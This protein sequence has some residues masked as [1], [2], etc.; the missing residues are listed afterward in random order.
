MESLKRLSQTS[1]DLPEHN[2]AEYF[3]KRRTGLSDLHSDGES[4]W[5]KVFRWHSLPSPQS[6]LCTFCLTIDFERLFTP[7]PEQPLEVVQ[8]HLA[9]FITWDLAAV[10]RNYNCPF[11][12]LLL[13]TL[14]LTRLSIPGNTLYIMGHIE[15]FKTHILENQPESILEGRRLWLTGSARCYDDYVRT[16]EAH[17]KK[18]CLD[19]RMAY[20]NAIVLGSS[21]TLSHKPIS[22]ACI[23]RFFSKCEETHGNSCASMSLPSDTLIQLRV[24]DIFQNCLVKAPR[25][26]KYFALSYVWGGVDQLRLT[27]QSFKVLSTPSSSPKIF[28][29]ASK[30][31]KDAIEFCRL[32][33]QPYLW[34]DTL[35][36][37]QDDPEDQ[38]AQIQTMGLIYSCAYATIVAAEGIDANAGLPGV[39]K[40]SRGV[41]ISEYVEGV[42]FMAAQRHVIFS[43]EESL[44]NTRGWTFQEK[45][46][47]NRCIVFTNSQVFF[48]CN[49]TLQREDNVLEDNSHCLGGLN[50]IG[51]FP[52]LPVHFDLNSKF[53]LVAFGRYQITVAEYPRRQFTKDEDILNAFMG[54]QNLFSP[55]LGEFRW[56]LPS[57]CFEAALT[58]RSKDKFPIKKREGF[59]S[60]SWAGWKDY[61]YSV[62]WEQNTGSS[63]N[64]FSYGWGSEVTWFQLNEERTLDKIS[65]EKP[66][67]FSK[68]QLE[69]RLR[70]QTRSKVHMVHPPAAELPLNLTC[71]LSKYLVFWTSSAKLRVG[72]LHQRHRE[73]PYM[74][75]VDP[76]MPESPFVHDQPEFGLQTF[77]RDGMVK[78]RYVG[79]IC[80]D[81]KWR[82]TQPDDLDFITIAT[83]SDCWL[84]AMLIEWR[85]WVA[86]RVQ[87]C[88]DPIKQK[89]WP[90]S[91][92]RK[93]IIMG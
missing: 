54:V 35:C 58:W 6:S 86:Y 20:H 14:G 3:K 2:I 59:P 89:D 21:N 7:L 11:C 26:C 36:I 78:S 51:N 68:T 72:R 34:V 84:F 31:V 57:C 28:Q 71:P 1:D 23:S 41:K 65:N 9:R 37:I 60:W 15:G 91:S 30:T 82:A 63:S 73:L 29:H 55:F 64:A 38:R 25:D 24:I 32:I 12:R 67:K 47:S 18:E 69:S 81:P 13:R 16:P 50:L 22:S 56:G 70:A 87:M 33:G 10:R 66:H 85:E 17:D 5:N 46:F 48:C 44:W 83:N 77:Y 92:E 49:I 53:V 80:L 52:P 79:T 76:L 43:M 61:R 4:I 45:L 19:Q 27:R 8:C 39:Q 62:N 40:Y 88:S 75:F 93:M 42:E 90:L 74:E